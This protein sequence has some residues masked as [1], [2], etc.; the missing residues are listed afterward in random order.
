MC[1]I[2]YYDEVDFTELRSDCYS[3]DCMFCGKFN[4]GNYFFRYDEFAADY[5]QSRNPGY[6]EI[7]E[8]LYHVEESTF[9]ELIKSLNQQHITPWTTK[10]CSSI[11]NIEY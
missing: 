7:K 3:E 10:I 8:N 1:E 2:Y 11:L 4:N 6:N 5:S 9:Y